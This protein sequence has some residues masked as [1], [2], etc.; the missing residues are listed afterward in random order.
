MFKLD[1]DP[2]LSL[3]TEPDGFLDRYG[4]FLL[5]IKVRVVGR[6]VQTIETDQNTLA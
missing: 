4:E 2:F 1:W 6:Q 3:L 5:Q